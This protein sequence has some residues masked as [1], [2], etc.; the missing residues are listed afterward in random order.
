MPVRWCIWAWWRWR[1]VGGTVN[2]S[3]V[4]SL[5]E[6]TEQ[7]RLKIILFQK[8]DVIFYLLIQ[9][10]VWGPLASGF[11]VVYFMAKSCPE[12]MLRSSAFAD[13][14]HGGNRSE[15]E[16]NWLWNHSENR[17]NVSE[18]EFVVQTVSSLHW[19]VSKAKGSS[20]HTGTAVSWCGS[21]STSKFGCCFGRRSSSYLY[22]IG[23]PFPISSSLDMEGWVYTL[24]FM[25]VGQQT[26][27]LCL[28]KGTIQSYADYV[29]FTWTLQRWH[30]GSSHDRQ[31]PQHL[32]PLFPN[33]KI[34]NQ[35][36]HNMRFK[37]IDV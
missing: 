33:P 26:L 13:C 35:F 15:K 30:A 20:G 32:V 19:P 9:F 31:V 4:S 10:D 7:N 21:I 12:T 8:N 34:V 22:R 37:S 16:E 3:P 2:M 11:Q 28:W 23:K 1:L 24:S 29:H 17:I 5:T 25:E 18:Q 6:R 14:Y 27:R 36:F